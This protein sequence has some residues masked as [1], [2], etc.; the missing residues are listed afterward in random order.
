MITTRPLTRWIAAPLACLLAIGPTIAGWAH[1]RA[2]HAET[3]HREQGSHQP[4]GGS[5]DHDHQTRHAGHEHGVPATGS[6]ASV[7]EDHADSAHQAARIEAGRSSR[8]DLA[9]GARSEPARIDLTDIVV[10][11]P[12]DASPDRPS[13]QTHHPPNLPRGPPELS[14]GF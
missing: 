12:N 9:L 11:S 7:A 5:S 6:G 4:H 1:D 14:S 13:D 10:A 8:A 3:S 2:H